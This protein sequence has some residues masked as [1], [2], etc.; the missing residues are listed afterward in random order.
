LPIFP[1]TFWWNINM[2]WRFNFLNNYWSKTI[3]DRTEKNQK[4]SFSFFDMSRTRTGEVCVTKR[5]QQWPRASIYKKNI[6]RILSTSNILYILIWI[7]CACKIIYEYCC[8]FSKKGKF[9]NTCI[10]NRNK[11]FFLFYLYIWL[12]WWQLGVSLNLQC[13]VNM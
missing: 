4:F 13:N 9:Y 12:Y 6:C 7:T 1:V 5:K 8:F 2:A 3:W 11:D 10:E